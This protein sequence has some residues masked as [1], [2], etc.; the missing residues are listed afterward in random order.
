M[1][2]DKLFGGVKL[3]KLNT[4]RK[5]YLQVIRMPFIISTQVSKGSWNIQPQ[6]EAIALF[7][8]NH[9]RQEIIKQQDK[10]A[11]NFEQHNTL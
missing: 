5:R 3:G 11:K 10:P 4:E 8:G 6:G 1:R 2:V 9:H 7:Q